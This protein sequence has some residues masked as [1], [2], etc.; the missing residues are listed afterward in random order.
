VTTGEVNEPGPGS[1]SGGSRVMNKQRKTVIIAYIAFLC[2]LALFF[3]LIVGYAVSLQHI[4]SFA[5]FFRKTADREERFWIRLAFIAI[6]NLF[7]FSSVI[8]IGL[9]IFLKKK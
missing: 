8:F 2:V 6:T 1:A 4:T 7:A 9:L 3:L 5:D